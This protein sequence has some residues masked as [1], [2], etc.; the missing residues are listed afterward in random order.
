MAQ[1]PYNDLAQRIFEI[2][3]IYC[4]FPDPILKTQCKHINKTP[5]DI[6]LQDLPVL[7]PRIARSVENFT[8]PEKGKAVETAILKLMEK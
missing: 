3:R 6:V 4:Y 5:A 1:Q 7:A 8:N 2:I